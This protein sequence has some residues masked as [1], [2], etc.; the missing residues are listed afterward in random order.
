MESIKIE[1]ENKIRL[2]EASN[3]ELFNILIRIINK[4]DWIENIPFD[5]FVNM[6]IS[7]GY[8]KETAINYYKIISIE[9]S[10]KALDSYKGEENESI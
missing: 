3:K 6:L 5:V 10:K 7:L 9:L 4:N 1:L 8:T 2:L